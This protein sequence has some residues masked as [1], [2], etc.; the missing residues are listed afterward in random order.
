MM[1][2]LHKTAHPVFLLSVTLLI[3]NDWFLKYTFHNALTGKLSDFAGLFA[4]PFFWSLIFDAHKR[5]IHIATALLFVFWK[6]GFSQPLIDAMNGLGLPIARTVDF[7]DN[8]AILFALASWQVLKA[9]VGV[10]IKPFFQKMVMGVACLAFMATTLPPRDTRKFVNIDKTYPFPFSKHELVSRLNMVQMEEIREINKL[11]GLV[12][13]DSETNVFHYHGS[14]DTLA[15]LLDCT[16]INDQDTIQLK[17]SFAEIALSGD[18]TGSTLKLI[19]VWRYVPMFSD[20][21][22]REKTIR[23]FERRII[24]KINKFR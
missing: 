15:V 18:E 21:D 2:N 3:L 12:D 16:Q 7:T 11:S 5:T 19:S 22:Y 4:F 24:N 10:R 13:F 8:V 9:D 20:K 17:T 23:Q 14:S 1:K 6:S